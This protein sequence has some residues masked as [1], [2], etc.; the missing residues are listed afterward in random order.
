M[1]KTILTVLLL[2]AAGASSADVSATVVG[3]RCHQGSVVPYRAWAPE[4]LKAGAAGPRWG[5][6]PLTR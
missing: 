1:K 5:T 6:T 4:G 3:R 2:V